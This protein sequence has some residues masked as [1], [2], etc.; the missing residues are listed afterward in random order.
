MQPRYR[1]RD[2]LQ[3]KYH[4]EGLTQ[5]EIAEECGVSPRTVR[6]YMNRFSIETRAV[7]GADHPLYGQERTEEVRAEI[8]TTME[9]RELSDETKSRLAEAHEGRTLPPETRQKIADSLTG[10]TRSEETRRRMS[11]STAG[12]K[13]PNWKGGYSRR[14]GSGWAVAR[15]RVRERDEV[16]QHCGHDGSERRLEVH[17]VVPVRQFRRADSASLEDAHDE[18]NLVL[19]CRRCHGRADHGLIEFESGVDVPE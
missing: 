9:G 14:Y 7:E 4:G 17:H 11:R 16:C 5:R 19:L 6:K 13:N 8:S 1:N 10:T 3:R 2:W 15:E 18:S 12:E